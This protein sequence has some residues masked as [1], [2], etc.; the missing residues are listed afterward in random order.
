MTGGEPEVLAPHFE[1]ESG[2]WVL[3]RETVT[4]LSF[5]A[6][7]P[8]P[9]R[10]AETLSTRPRILL[11][12]ASVRW[13][14]QS[15]KN[16][17]FSVIG[18]DLFGDTDTRAA[19][20]VFYRISPEDASEIERLRQKIDAV[21]ERHQARQWIVGGLGL[22]SDEPS[23]R[24]S[25]PKALSRL[26]DGLAI[27]VPTTLSKIPAADFPL[28]QTAEGVV[29]KQSVP[30]R[31]LVKQHQSCGGLGVRFWDRSDIES[32]HAIESGQASLQ[33]FISGHRYG[34]V[35]IANG[36]ATH[37]LGM[38]RSLRQRVGSQPFVYAGSIGP[39]WDPAVPFEAMT[40][41]SRR[42]AAEYSIRGLFNLDFIHDRRGRWWLLE[43]NARP[44]GS[45]EIVERSAW[46]S[47]K[48]S[49]SKSLMGLHIAAVDHKPYE[50]D[51]LETSNPNRPNSLHLKQIVYARGEGHFQT[52]NEVERIADV[53]KDQTLIKEGHP[54]ATSISTCTS[55]IRIGP[56]YT[57]DRG[58]IWRM[59]RANTRQVR[60]MVKPIGEST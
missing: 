26:C 50:P 25:G 38:T 15:S 6:N 46:Q 40:E 10:S 23:K 11:V 28:D 49:L 14:A 59:I 4:N 32:R 55:A 37:L 36:K 47:G 44:S 9:G 31:W 52:P 34:L 18:M 17:G 5:P 53:P 16:A 8:I 12:G 39:C 7:Q 60:G 22:L 33:P 20:E 3:Q 54:I 41:L 29:S 2:G 42:V 1:N 57:G 45:C 27:S 30:R 24:E 43:L 51:E 58:S 56:T 13:A 48:L 21:A 35:A 19:C